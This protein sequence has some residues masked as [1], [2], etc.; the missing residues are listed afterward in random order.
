MTSRTSPSCV[1]P[2]P[3]IPVAF[4]AKSS[5]DPPRSRSGASPIASA[6][7]Q[8]SSTSF[9]TPSAALP[10]PPHSTSPRGSR[11]PPHWGLPSKCTTTATGPSAPA[12]PPKTTLPANTEGP[13]ADRPAR[14][15]PIKHT[16]THAALLR[17]LF[18]QRTRCELADGTLGC[19]VGDQL[20]RARRDL[21]LRRRRSL[22]RCHRSNPRTLCPGVVLQLR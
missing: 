11:P 22:S 21:K 15:G 5:S 9:P 2:T 17:N 16:F 13:T 6:G 1:N 3:S 10:R 14:G 20:R 8:P 18:N 19:R 7:P 12:T 4:C